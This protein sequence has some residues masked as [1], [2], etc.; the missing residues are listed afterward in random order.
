M[1]SITCLWYGG[2]KRQRE[3]DRE[4]EARGTGREGG[5]T[6][7]KKTLLEKGKTSAV[8]GREGEGGE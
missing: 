7:I 1:Y 6:P 8:K 2:Y 4:R 5:Y 3:I